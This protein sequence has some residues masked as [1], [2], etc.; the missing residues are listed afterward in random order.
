[1]AHVASER[2]SELLRD[3][4]ERVNEIAEVV[5]YESVPSFNK[6][7]RKWQ[8]ESPTAYRRRH[9]PERTLASH[10]HRS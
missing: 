10:S 5:G 2:A 8:G 6:A 7:F 4:G 1:M 3:T 9:T